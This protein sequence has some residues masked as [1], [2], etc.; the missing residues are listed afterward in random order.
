MYSESEPLL[1]QLKREAMKDGQDIA[2]PLPVTK[3]PLQ[4]LTLRVCAWTTQLWSKEDNTVKMFVTQEG[5]KQGE[6]DTYAAGLN[7]LQLALGRIHS[8]PGGA[9]NTTR[10]L[11]FE[12]QFLVG[13]LKILE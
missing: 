13:S 11:A 1:G 12:F 9:G 4:T 7:V 10:D 3:T 5:W 2:S 8:T 6:A